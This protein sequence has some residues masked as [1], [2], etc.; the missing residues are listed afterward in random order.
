M[1]LTS[2]IQSLFGDV[3]YVVLSL[4]VL[5]LA[6]IIKDY[7]TPYKI[8]EEL[9]IK[10][11]P[12][13]GVSIAGYYA[14][15]FAVF[16][17]ALADSS[18]TVQSVSYDLA[19]YGY[20][21]FIVFAY[22]LGGIILLN[23][24]RLIVDKLMLYKFS[25]TKEIITDRNSGSGAVEGAAY[26]ASGLVIAG[27]INGEGGGALSALVFFLLGQVVL[28]LY[29]VFY[30]WITS[31]DIHVELEKD[32]VPA[33]VAMGGNL[34]AIGIILLKSL[35]GDF[36]SWTSNISDF[37]YFAIIGF[38]VLF[39]IRYALDW[40]LLPKSTLSHEIAVD[41]NLSAAYIEAIV[42]MGTAAVIFFAM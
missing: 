15:V 11:N 16:I 14:G 17:G 40:M 32:N 5:T 9:T 13:L 30:Q 10:D 22:S 28:L 1:E 29:G 39:I 31:Y 26:V 4:I 34:I 21:L 36:I 41:R 8:D 35:K 19:K 7:L 25:V 27:A 18:N 42:L 24:C 37:F 2:E 3:G 38:I 23:F 20:D 33:G 12:A 6:K